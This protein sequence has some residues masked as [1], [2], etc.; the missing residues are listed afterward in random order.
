MKEVRSDFC[1]CLR[2]D[3]GEALPHFDA[4]LLK[5]CFFLLLLVLCREDSRNG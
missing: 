1:G 3:L 5:L 4:G 2:G